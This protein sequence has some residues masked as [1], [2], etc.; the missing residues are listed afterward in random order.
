MAKSIKTQ[1]DCIS[2]QVLSLAEGLEAYRQLRQCVIKSGLLDRTYGYYTI[3]TLFIFTAFFASFVGVYFGENLS[4]IILLSIIFAFFS[5]QIGGLIHDAGHRSIFKTPLANDIF[6][7]TCTLVFA[8]CYN[9]WRINHNRHHAYPNQETKDPDMEIPYGFTPDRFQKLSGFMGAIKKY[10]KYT[11]YP[12]GVLASLTM[13]YKRYDYFKENFGPAIYWEI[14][15]FVISGFIRFV[16]PF[17]LF[18]FEKASVFLV[19]STLFEGFY[20]FH[21]FA[22][23]HKGMAELGKDIKLSFLEHQV[24]TSRNIK[25]HPITD[26]VYLGLNYQI[27]H[28]LFPNTPRPNLK[29]LR[30]YVTDICQKYHLN[31]SEASVIES[32]R[33]ILSNLSQIS[34]SA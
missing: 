10:Q 7:H 28:H 26:F 29:K 34:Q 18:G 2:G 16:F 23:N 30:P 32:N 25:G 33:I 9:N 12:F 8:A 21:I 19:V 3:L 13:R 4:S 24:L 14:V 1:E 31:F 27:E 5:V 20:M 6:A 15:L 22:P 17:V 11:Y